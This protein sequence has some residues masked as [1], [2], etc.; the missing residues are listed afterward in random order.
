MAKYKLYDS[1][2]SAK[3]GWLLCITVER[4]EWA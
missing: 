3:K 4:E 1:I 2:E